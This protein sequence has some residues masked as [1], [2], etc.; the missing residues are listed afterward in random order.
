MIDNLFDYAANEQQ[1]AVVKKRNPSAAKPLPIA[2][3]REALAFDPT[4]PTFLRWKVRP[5][6][7]FPTEHG[8]K[9]SNT[10]FAGTPAGSVAK[11]THTVY[12]KIML[13]GVNY[14]T[15]RLVY[16]L[17]YGT[18]PAGMHIDHIDGNGTNNSPSNLRLATQ[19]QNRQN[20]SKSSSNTSGVLGVSWNA[21]SQKWEARI[22]I[23]GRSLHLG[24]FEEFNDAVIA[25]KSAE[26]KHFGEY[27]F[28]AS[29]NSM[30]ITGQS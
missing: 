20:S 18:D 25:R 29:R 28:D 22:K 6:H 15:H 26:V 12:W 2:L 30:P 21:K 14:R 16:L 7:H 1:R 4:S 23:H 3:I 19:S 11:R 10:Q 24:L 17:F 8:W 5:R 9:K 13:D 27:S